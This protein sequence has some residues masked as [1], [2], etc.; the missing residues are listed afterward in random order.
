M[1]RLPLTFAILALALPSCALLKDLFNSAFQQPTLTFRSASLAEAS[2]SG[3]TLNLTYALTNPNPLGISLASVDYAL[4]IE[5][6]Q[7]VAGRPPQ[8]LNLPANGTSELT[9]PAELKFADLG[10]VLQVFLNKDFARYRAEGHLGVSTPLG[11]V[12]FPLAH[13]D[14]FEIPKVPEVTMQSPRITNLS[15]SSATLEIPLSVTNRNSF[16]LPIAGLSG[17]LRIA[18]ANVGTLST[19][20]LGFLP[21]RAAKAVTLPLTVSFSSAFAAANALRAGSATVAFSGQV[22][23][24]ASSLPLDFSQ[25]VTFRR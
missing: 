21:A 5:G 16:P 6:K 1:R 23:S 14:Q 20:S 17:A 13:E 9:F 4:F 19:G 15:F 25:S 2:L 22:Q 18:G 8:G 3:A 12:S 10:P 7:V 24:G 11:I